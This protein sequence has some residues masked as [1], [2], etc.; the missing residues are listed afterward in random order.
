MDSLCKNDTWDLVSLPPDKRALPCKW[1]F[2]KKLTSDVLPRYKARL[3][4]KGFKQEKGVDFD[5]LESREDD[6]TQVCAWLG[7]L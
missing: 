1:V 5:L 7:S 4:A 3:V 2:K 6:Y